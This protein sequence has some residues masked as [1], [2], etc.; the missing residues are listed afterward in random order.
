[1]EF[2]GRTYQE[3]KT[4]DTDID[5]RKV[6]SVSEMDAYPLPQITATLD[7]LR[8]ARYLTTLDLKTG[9]WQVPLTDDSRP[10]TA[11]TVP[12]RGLRQFRVMPFGLHAAPATF[13]RLLDRVLGLELEPYVL[14]YLDDIIIATATFDEHLRIL[15]EVFL[16]LRDA[17][18]RPNVKKCQ[19]CR[20]SLK[21]LGHVI[22][23][24]G[25]RTD[26]N[27]ISAIQ[28]WSAPTTLRQVRRFLGVASWYRRFVANFSTIAAPLTRLTKKQIRWTWGEEEERAFRTLKQTLVSAPVLACPDF[29]RRFI[30]QTDASKQGLGAVLTQEFEDGERVIAY[31]SR[32]LNQAERNYSATE[33]ECLAVVWGIRRMRD[34]L[35]G[36]Q[37]TV[38]TDHQSLRWIQRMESPSGRLG[39]WKFELQQYN[40]DIR[41]RQ[42]SANKVADA[43]F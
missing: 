43:L 1:M 6:N 13:Q 41:Y 14:V 7:K 32:T 39:R 33:L 25:I 30:L 27:K 28:N 19:F 42:G 35:E 12:G 16:R 40:V 37:F 22:D 11:F 4:A 15:A 34:Y 31:A 18:L 9:Y 20:D 3:K 29:S 21:Y 5:F 2:T 36:Y 8:G 24:R 10:I 23:H 38:L 26:A 17:R